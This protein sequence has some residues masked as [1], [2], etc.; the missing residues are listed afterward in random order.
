MQRI[1]G[2]I[3][4]IEVFLQGRTTDFSVELS[5]IKNAQSDG[6]FIAGYPKETAMIAQQARGMGINIPIFSTDGISSME[7]VRLGGAAVEGIRFIAFFND[8][9]KEN[10]AEKFTQDFKTRYGSNPDSTAALAYDSANI[11]VEGI[12]KNGATRDG[13]YQYMNGLK[14][15]PGV[16]GNITFDDH[17]DV[18]EVIKI[19]TVRNGKF[20]LD[21]NQP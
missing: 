10:G 7:L 19:V 17:H 3:T 9:M 20:I 14:D 4:T 5:K 21:T 11:I 2:E 8:D 13:V 6:I 15:Y 16:T 1:G 18:E 12:R